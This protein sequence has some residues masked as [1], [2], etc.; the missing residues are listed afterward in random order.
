MVAVGVAALAGELAG[1]AG[2]GGEGTGGGGGCS[3][4]IGRVGS[5]VLLG[6]PFTVEVTLSSV[7]I[8]IGKMT[9]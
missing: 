2:C 5:A 4:W 8:L 7:V 1:W 3:G 6:A 9:K